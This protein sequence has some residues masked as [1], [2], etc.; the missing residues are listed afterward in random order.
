MRLILSLA[1]RA[2]LRLSIPPPCRAILKILS[3][4]ARVALRLE[5]FF[6]NITRYFLIL[7]LAA[8]AALRLARCIRESGDV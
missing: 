8:R 4:A 6:T 1:A 7:S 3:L 2:A 5:A